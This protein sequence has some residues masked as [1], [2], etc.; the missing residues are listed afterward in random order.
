MRDRHDSTG[1]L[2]TLVGLPTLVVVGEEDV[3]T[4]PEAARRM[5][6]LIPGAR[7]VV[8]PGAGHVPPL[9][10]PSETTA[11]IREFLRV[12]G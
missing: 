1:L 9:E 6:T 5:A 3:L 10:R 11:E 4:P 2:P 7:L 8:I 12:V